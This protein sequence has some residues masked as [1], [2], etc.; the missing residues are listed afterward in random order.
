MEWCCL[1]ESGLRCQCLQAHRE[2]K[3]GGFMTPESATWLYGFEWPVAAEGSKLLGQWTD[4][5]C[6]KAVCYGP[7]LGL[8]EGSVGQERGLCGETAGS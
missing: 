4:L 1:G 5:K 8:V 6:H 3:S 2:P 7:E